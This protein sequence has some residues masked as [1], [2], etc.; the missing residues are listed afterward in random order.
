MN[1]KQLEHLLRAS[2]SVAATQDLIVVGSQ[3]ILGAFPEAPPELLIS[4]EAD[5]YPLHEP[6]K[7]DLIDGSIGE[8]SPFHETFGYYA[9]GIGPE[10]AILPKDWKTRL[11]KVANANT[12]G[13]TGWCLSPA[14][15]AISKLIAGRAKD[16]HF[17]RTMLA[18]GLVARAA[19]VDLLGELPAAEANAVRTR[20][21]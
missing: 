1:R 17:V 9:H 8:L 11:I 2:G 12:G 18:A 15:L 5:V 13:I 19:I 14:D 21:D 10:T 16:F 4:M 7:A 3:A 20:L 6:E